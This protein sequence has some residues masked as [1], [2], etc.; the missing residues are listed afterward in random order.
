MILITKLI[1]MI[2]PTLLLIEKIKINH[3]H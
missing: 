3:K 2:I 1:S